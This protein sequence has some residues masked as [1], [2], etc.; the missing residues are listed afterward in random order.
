M[1]RKQILPSV[2]NYEAKLATIIQTKK[3][4]GISSPM[5]E[6]MLKNIDKP[7]ELVS[8]HVDKLETMID[9]GFG[10]EKEAAFFAANEMLPLMDAIRKLTDSIEKNVSKDD[11]PIP[12]YNEILFKSVE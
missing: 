6:K 10:N 12:D 3:N 5:E 2:F 4:S 11:W 8:N 7:L 9:K 1:L